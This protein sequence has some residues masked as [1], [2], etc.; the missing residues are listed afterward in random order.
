MSAVNVA[1]PGC[2]L[3]NNL[4]GT[5]VRRLADEE[6]SIVRVD[7]QAKLSEEKE[8]ITIDFT[9]T[10]AM[11]SVCATKNSNDKTFCSQLCKKN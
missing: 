4:E 2:I 8:S 5:F 10:P 1:V 6:V 11:A 9:G 7:L 3:D